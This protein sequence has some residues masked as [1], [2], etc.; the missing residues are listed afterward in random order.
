MGLYRGIKGNRIHGWLLFGTT[1]AC[2]ARVVE[3]NVSNLMA[4][5]PDYRQGMNGESPSQ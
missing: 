1:H 2:C 4:R 3:R 5:A